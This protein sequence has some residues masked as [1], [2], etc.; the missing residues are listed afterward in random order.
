MKCFSCGYELDASSRCPS[1]GQNVKIYKKLIA[2]SNHL[3][4]EGIFA[5]SERRMYDAEERLN[6]ALRINKH[7][8]DARNLL[9]LVYY[10][11][12]EYAKAIEEWAIS[13]ALKPEGNAAAEYLDSIYGDFTEM[14]LVKNVIKKYN[15]ALQYAKSDSDDLAILQFKKVL[16]LCPGHIKANQLLA[17]LNA[18]AGKF[19]RARSY[20]K[21]A[22]RLDGNNPITKKLM[23]KIDAERKESLKHRGRVRKE[24]VSYKNGNETIIQPR[25]RISGAPA[26]LVNV[27]TGVVVGALAVYFL[28]V[29]QI[30]HD[31]NSEAAKTITEA[32]KQATAKEASVSALE[33]QIASL[34]EELADYESASAVSDNAEKG[35]LALI[36]LYEMYFED[37]S[38]SY[39]N[40][41][42]AYLSMDLTVMSSSA[43]KSYNEFA[44]V[45]YDG[46]DEEYEKALYAYEN[47]DLESALTLLE[48]IT[49]K[50]PMYS[51]GR[52]MYYLG[53]CYKING[54]TSEAISCFEKIVEVYPNGKIG[55]KAQKKI[56]ALS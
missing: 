16:E 14:E 23:K 31:A 13:K 51:N 10:E 6:K 35:Y 24:S 7:N 5:A 54:D 50:A 53:L 18:K 27:L 12:G 39:A 47:D 34:E 2:S 8:I 3:Y 9:G 26:I 44:D 36:E 46:L 55:K 4:N 37:T 11:S 33:E 29:P 22:K 42:S 40:T 49:S 32:N 52:A 1:C 17:I 30:K 20:L 15:Q 48:D 38:S 41:K 45:L 25:I 19:E 56:D 28:V 21:T 43:L